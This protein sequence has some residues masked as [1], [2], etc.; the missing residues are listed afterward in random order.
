MSFMPGEPEKV[1]TFKNSWHQEYFTD[2]NDSNFSQKPKDRSISVIF[3][4]VLTTL[5]ASVF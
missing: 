2:L 1:P 5:E 4:T 3:L